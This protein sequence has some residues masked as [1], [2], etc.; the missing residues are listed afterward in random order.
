MTFYPTNFNPKFYANSNFA[1]KNLVVLVLII[2]QFPFLLPHVSR[3]GS[4]PTAAAAKPP[5]TSGNFRRGFPAEAAGAWNARADLGETVETAP[6]AHGTDSADTW[7]SEAPVVSLGAPSREGQGSGNETSGPGGA[8]AQ[9]VKR[10]EAGGGIT[11]ND[12]CR[13]NWA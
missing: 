12:F 13:R 6:A 4:R 5:S 7:T 1:A 8:A 10:D 2:T 3:T 11:H 9:A